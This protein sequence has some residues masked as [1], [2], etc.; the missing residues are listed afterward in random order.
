M[1]RPHRRTRVRD[2]AVSTVPVHESGRLKRTHGRRRSASMVVA[3]GRPSDSG[4]P[5]GSPLPISTKETVR[6]LAPCDCSFPLPL[7]DSAGVSPAFRFTKLESFAPAHGEVYRRGKEKSLRV[8]LAGS[9]VEVGSVTPPMTM[10]LSWMGHTEI[11]A[12]TRR[13]SF[14]LGPWLSLSCSR[15]RRRSRA[16]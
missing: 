4:L 10:R 16:G 5:T 15:R 11:R 9:L 6:W 7:R 3:A 8:G 14:R 2:V 12:F 1:R 13:G